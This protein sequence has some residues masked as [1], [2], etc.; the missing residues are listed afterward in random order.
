MSKLGVNIDHVATVRQARGE[1]HPDPVNAAKLCEQAGAHSIVAHLREDRRHINDKDVW[2]LR[3]AVKTRFNLEM[4]VSED[5]VK[6]ACR[7][8]PD[9]ATLVP[10]KRKELT[11]EGGLDVL[12]HSHRLKQ[13]IKRLNQKNIIVSLFID[14]KEKQILKSK[15]LGAHSVELH[16][17]CYA[18][19]KTKLSKE[20]EL[21][22]IQ[23]AARFG[24]KIGIIVNAGHGLNYK[25]AKPI[26]KI[27]EI[28]E[29]NIGHSIISYSIFAG[30][31]KAVKDMLKLVK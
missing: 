29:L 30:L 17:G 18:N 20:C 14:P 7:L 10:E 5:I 13:V 31:K 24:K 9:Q 4:S 12:R 8:K 1:S 19:A 25:N 23:K 16:T 11:T 26:A 3:K 15:E 2:L 21:K 22:K 28:H 6:I 27:K